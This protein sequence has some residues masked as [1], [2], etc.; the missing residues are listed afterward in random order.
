MQVSHPFRVHGRYEVTGVRTPPSPGPFVN[1]KLTSLGPGCDGIER[2]WISAYGGTGGAIGVAV[3]LGGTMQSYRFGRDHPCLYSAAAEDH[4]TL[5]LCGDMARLVR[6]K[7]SSGEVDTFPTGVASNLP[8]AGMAFDGATRRLFLAA[9][10][11]DRPTGFSFDTRTK[12]AVQFQD[13]WKGKYH[14]NSFPNGDGTWSLLLYFPAQLIRWDP[15][16]DD[17]WPSAVDLG[18]TPLNYLYR[19]PFVEGRGRYLPSL[20]WYDAP[21]DQLRSAGPRPPREMLWFGCHGERLFG[22]EADSADLRIAVWDLRRDRIDD[23][24][25]IPDTPLH[26]VTVSQKGD[27]AAMSM[28]GDF[29]VFDGESGGMKVAARVTAMPRPRTNGA[30]MIGPDRLLGTTFIT[31]RFWEADLA[32]GKTCDRGRAAP[33]SGQVTQIQRIGK[34][35]YFAAYTGGELTRYDLDQPAAF[36]TNP[37]VVA[38]HPMAMRPV[39]SLQANRV[40]WYACSRKYGNLGSVLLRHDTRSGTTRWGVDPLG[41]RQIMTMLRDPAC[42]ELL[43]GSTIHADMAS[44]TPAVDHAALGRID[45][46]DLTLRDVRETPGLRVDV[47][48]WVRR[49]VALC[50]DCHHGGRKPYLLDAATLER[51][52]VPAMEMPAHIAWAGRVGRFVVE[53]QDRL[54]LHD[55]R[56]RRPLV[57]V[58]VDSLPRDP[59]ARW[60]LDGNHLVMTDGRGGVWVVR[61]ILNGR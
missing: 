12:E 43:C 26:G 42:G 9:K 37:R 13:R 57:R 17:V 10:P 32:T 25:R 22:C 24:T 34:R 50:C 29:H 51:V 33:G 59:H 1:A 31:Q 2:F 14:Y 48:G 60:M 28:F 3:D 58:L 49:G 19:M 46:D 36:P 44:A 54:E 53:A 23:L 6:L 15:R 47:V 20:G 38:Q 55:L 8:F 21:R 45:A 35:L 41:P 52:D 40:L 18:Q 56:R 16:T 39:A 11:G 7:L 27:V 4:D 30:R 5:W 61:D